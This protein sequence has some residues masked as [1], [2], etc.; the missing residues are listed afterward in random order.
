MRTSTKLNLK[1]TRGGGSVW[2]QSKVGRGLLLWLISLVIL[3][4]LTQL[5]NRMNSLDAGLSRTA[6]DWQMRLLREYF[7]R[8]AMVDPVL[9]GVDDDAIAKFEEPLALWHRHFAQ[10]FEAIKRGK[11]AA[12]AVDIVLPPRSY[13]SIIP[14]LD[15]VLLNSLRNL[16]QQ[17]P[18]TIAHTIDA[19]GRL[20]DINKIYLRMLQDESFS[21]DQVI[22]DPDRAARRFDER[23]LPFQ[24]RMPS[25]AG[26]VARSLGKP[27]NVGY[28]DFSVGGKVDYIPMQKVIDMLAANDPALEKIFRGRVVLVGSVMTGID[29]WKLPVLLAAWDKRSS[30]ENLNQPG[31]VIHIQTL[32]SMLGNGLIKPLPMWQILTLCLLLL[33]IVFIESRISLFLAAFLVLPVIIFIISVMFITANWL[34]PVVTLTMALWVGVTVRGVADSIRTLLEKNRFKASFAGSVSPAVLQEMLAGNLTAGISSETAEVCVLFSDIRGFTALSESLTPEL[35]TAVLTRYFDRMVAC[36]YR[37]EGTID[38][39]IGDGMMV[40][41]GVPRPT[42]DPCGD[43]VKCAFEMTQALKKLNEEFAEEKLPPLVIGIGINYGKVV[44]GNIGSTE[45]HN[46]SAI[47][48]VVNV[49]SRLEG[50]TKD[51][52][53]PIMMTDAVNTRLGGGVELIPC[54]EQVLRGHSPLTVWGVKKVN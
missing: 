5:P 15:L 45:R 35:T 21:L 48:D 38:K 31:V 13:D 24:G 29:S 44:V 52:G 40:L 54:G 9:I 4:A 6:F 18:L 19:E 1:Q 7:P 37:Y 46:Y 16:K 36:V 53:M 41:F 30:F 47:G 51:L 20:A 28:I 43:A 12:V 34:L 33:A 8:E 25:M 11:P 39:F 17:A 49:A 27:V 14:G 32:R 23:E 2:A 3:L 26:S 10:L 22:E 50:L 42:S